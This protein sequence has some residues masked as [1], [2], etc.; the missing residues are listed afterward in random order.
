MYGHQSVG[1][2]ISN[3]GV[4]SGGHSHTSST[5]SG[6]SRGGWQQTGMNG[7]GGGMNVNGGMMSVSGNGHGRLPSLSDNMGIESIINRSSATR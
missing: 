5:G 7:M 1:S 6:G 3:Q 2:Y 4:G